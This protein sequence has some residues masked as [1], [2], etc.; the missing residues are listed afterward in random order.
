MLC[1]V[2]WFQRAAERGYAPAQSILG[3]QYGGGEGVSK[4]KEK[5]IYWYRKAAEQGY[6]MAQS[7]LGGS[8][9]KVTACEEPSYG[10]RLD[11]SGSRSRLCRCDIQRQDG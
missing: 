1:P 2:K 10:A 6:D 5:M 9:S 3:V 7:N 11:Q 8:Y 4:D